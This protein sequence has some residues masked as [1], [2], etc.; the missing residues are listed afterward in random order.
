[1]NV[2]DISAWQENMD[3]GGLLDAGVAGVIVKLGERN[4]MDDMFLQ[5]IENAANYGLKIGIYYYAHA[6][7]QY[8]AK[9]EAAW[10]ADQVHQYFGDAGPELGIWYDA[11]DDGMTCADVTATC[12]AF[13]CYL[14]DAGFQYVG[15]YASYNWLS[16]GTIDMDSLADYVP[17]WVAQYYTENS[18]AA[19]KPDKNIKIWQYTDHL[20]DSLPYDGDLYYE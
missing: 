12:S 9:E 7:S 1:M 6:H 19:E 4:S 5:H 8:E 14:N 13:I 2:V 11:E 16:N 10:V 15:I 20:S 3:W 18:L 17:Y